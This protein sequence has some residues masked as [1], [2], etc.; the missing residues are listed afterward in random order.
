MRPLLSLGEGDDVLA[1]ERVAEEQLQQGD[2][3][4]LRSF[5]GRLA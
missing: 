2:I 1:V 3:A 5:G 4:Y